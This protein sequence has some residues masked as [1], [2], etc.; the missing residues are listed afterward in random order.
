[1]WIEYLIIGIT[2]AAVVAW[3]YSASTVILL[4]F[5]RYLGRSNRK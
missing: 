5:M 1:M 3:S 2:A 4:I